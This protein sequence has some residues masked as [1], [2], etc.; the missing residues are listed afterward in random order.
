[1]KR[2]M[3]SKIYIVVF[4]LLVNLLLG[5][6]PNE[7]HVTTAYNNYQFDKQVI[8]RLKDY[9]SLAI[10]IEAKISMFQKDIGEDG[11]YRAYRYSPT[12]KDQEH[13]NKL[14]A[15]ADTVA[16]FFNKIGANFIE[17]FD[18]FKD[19]TIKMSIRSTS[20]TTLPIIIDEALSYYPSTDSISRRAFPIRDTVLNKRWLYW[21]RVR[22]MGYF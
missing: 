16:Y 10:A 9:D 5:C 15:G 6:D 8:D 1:M 18:V 17:G 22:E 19:S 3:V 2:E 12:N 21:A 11:S 4:V 14:P 13:T 7:K 20:S